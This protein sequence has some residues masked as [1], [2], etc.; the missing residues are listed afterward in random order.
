MAVP[1]L[2]DKYI[3]IR[4]ASPDDFEQESLRTLWVDKDNGIQEIMGKHL[5]HNKTE[6]Q[7]Y[8]FDKHKFTIEEARCWVKEKQEKNEETQAELLVAKKSFVVG[9]MLLCTS[10]PNLTV[11]N[12]EAVKLT[13]E[14]YKSNQASAALN[15]RY[16]FYVE[17]VHA[18]MNGNGDYFYEEEL[19]KNYKSAGYQL[20]DWEHERDQIIGFSLDSELVTRVDHPLALAFTGVINRLSPYMQTEAQDG[21]TIISRDDLIRQR[22]FEGK[23]AVSMECYFDKCRCVECGYETD[24][25]LDFEFHTMLTHKSMIDSG[26]K[27]P[28]GLIGVDFVGWG[29]V[30]MPADGEAFVTSL[31][32]SDDGLIEDI[33]PSTDDQ[34]KYGCMAENVAFAKMAAKIDP[35]DVFLITNDG[36]L[37]FASKLLNTDGTKNVP[38]LEEKDKKTNKSTKINNKH[39]KR[40]ERTNRSSKGGFKMFGLND[41]ITSS[42]SLNDAIVVALRTLKDF[43]GDRS[44]QEE[45]V[46]AFAT[47]FGEA[48]TPKLMQSDF[49]VADIFTLTDQDKLAAIEAAREEEKNEAASKAAE[50]QTKIDTLSTEKEGLEATI[51]DKDKEITTLKNADKDREIAKKVDDFIADIKTAGVDLTETFEIDVRTLATAKLDDE[52]GM[53][54]LKGDLIASVKRSTLTAASNTMSDNSAG[55]DDGGLNSMAAKLEKAR[56]ENTK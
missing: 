46:T 4:V 12:A 53:K 5:K 30:G 33:I 49:R 44:L 19:T 40:L 15:D 6:V 2:T 47:E 26:Q 28:R 39:D 3:I 17:G 18:G 29:V 25:P 9:N 1:V 56:E 51:S 16:Y 42:M 35:S 32:T 31:R 23:L 43:Q 10:K 8:I 24:D 50:L 45:E 27:V 52:E 7:C 11:E 36:T 54:K 13:P 55:G 22:Y 37:A 34:A 41:K 21:D 48:V 38:N 14:N 20:I